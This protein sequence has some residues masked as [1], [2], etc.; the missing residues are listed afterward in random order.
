MYAYMRDQSIADN[1]SQCSQLLR[2]IIYLFNLGVNSKRP[3]GC[4][5]DLEDWSERIHV[6]MSLHLTIQPV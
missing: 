2:L 6:P 1:Y 3:D 5:V 4:R